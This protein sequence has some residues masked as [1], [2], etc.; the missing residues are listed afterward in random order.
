MDDAW[1]D[2]YEYKK[3]VGTGFQSSQTLDTF[4]VLDKIV[5]EV[6]FVFI[7]LPHFFLLFQ[8]ACPRPR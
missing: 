6:K 3:M 1:E 8:Y 4:M 5:M 7:N 2:K